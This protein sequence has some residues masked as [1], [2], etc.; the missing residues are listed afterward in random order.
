MQIDK[1]RVKNILCVRNDR[2]GEFLL[3]IPAL[4]AL[5]ETFVNAAIIMV[6]DPGVKDLIPCIPLIDEA[7]VWGRGNH[8]LSEKLKLIALLKRRNID[9]AVMLNPSKEFNI[10]TYLSAIPVRAGYDRKWGF[11]LT[12]KMEDTKHLRHLHEVEFNLELVSL[13]GANTSDLTLSLNVDNDII[14]S[15]LK[16]Y[17]IKEGED[18]VAL[19]PWTS[20]P[21]KQWPLDN[22]KELAKR[23]LNKQGIKVVM[24]GGIDEESK[25]LEFSNKF[26]ASSLVNLTGRLTLAQSAAFLKK[27]KLLVSGDSGPVHLASA[28]NTTVL[29]IFRNDLEGKTPRRWGPWGKGHKVIEKNSL[30]D[31]SVDEVFSVAM[32]ALDK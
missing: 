26:S 17:G 4:R 28:V 6:I 5:K 20:D 24:I 27:C 1:K 12:H 9:I 10:I 32:E 8:G 11:L 2:F 3:N 25:A 15:L 13:V 7:I 29:A 16:E 18:L 14:N 21:L 19:H 22:F 23:L 31:I 30:S